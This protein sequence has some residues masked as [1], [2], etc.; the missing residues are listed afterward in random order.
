[1]TPLMIV[2]LLTVITLAPLMKLIVIATLMNLVVV[3]M[4]MKLLQ[5]S[6]MAWICLMMSIVNSWI[7]MHFPLTI[8]LTVGMPS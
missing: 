1:M 3:A 7:M 5:L 8:L 2:T 6:T 4:L